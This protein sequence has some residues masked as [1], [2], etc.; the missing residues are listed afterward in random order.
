MEDNNTVWT[1][2]KLLSSHRIVIPE[3]QRDY[4][5]GR[6]DKHA[7]EIRKDIVTAFISALK[8]GAVAL[9]LDFIYGYSSHGIFIPLDGQQRLTTL[10]LLHLYIARSI[11]A[12]A[13]FLKNF[14]YETRQSATD[15]CTALAIEPI[16]FN[17]ERIGEDIEDQRWFLHSWK[18]DPT[19]C[20]MLRMLGEIHRQLAGFDLESLWV[21]LTRQDTSAIYF[22]FLELEQYNMQEDLYIKMNSRGKPLTRFENFKAWFQEHF[23]NNIGWHDKID[24]TWTNLFWPYRSA[25]TQNHVIDEEF[26][27]FIN[28]MLLYELSIRK[29][30]VGFR[31][32]YELVNSGADVPLSF[33]TEYS[34]FSENAVNYIEKTLDFL[35]ENSRFISEELMGLILWLDRE[36]KGEVPLFDNFIS[37][38][39]LLKSRVLFFALV[40]YAVNSKKGIPLIK[41]SL[42]QWMRIVRNLIENTTTLNQESVIDAIQ[43]LH[44]IGSECLDIEQR[45]GTKKGSI[46]FFN[47]DQLREEQEKLELFNRF[48]LREVIQEAENHSLFRG[49]VGFLLTE[50]F[51]PELFP[52]DCQAAASL[53]GDH[54]A[55]E[56]YKEGYLLIR[57]MLAKSDIDHTIRLYDN[58]EN[59]H[60]LLKN[61]KVRVAMH[62]I[63]IASRMF[64]DSQ[65][66]GYLNDIVNLYE[67]KDI[68]WRYY[69]IK[70]AV[71]LCD[72][73]RARYLREYHGEFY[74]FNNEGGNW[75]NNDNQFLLSNKRSEAITKLLKRDPS[76]IS[77]YDNKAHSI[78]IDSQSGRSHFRGHRVTLKKYCGAY[79]ARLNFLL[80]QVEVGFTRDE[81]PNIVGV[82]TETSNDYWICCERIMTGYSDTN[83]IVDDIDGKV[84]R[85]LQ[86]LESSL[87]NIILN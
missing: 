40:H 20:S 77:T 18:K 9:D 4:A 34:C 48:D 13:E 52:G 69:L 24:N 81:N 3:I 25:H 56:T 75:I 83:E 54:G 78:K 41:Q 62:K 10:Y 47:R 80:D 70:D 74:L 84:S 28:G 38:V 82:E 36:P 29:D 21:T 5:Q 1:L 30:A 32:L 17:V 71:L 50:I 53:F 79:T 61:E 76:Y 51:D 67:D 12:E 45:L 68:L 31:A 35:S 15:F 43:A 44:T 16:D 85:L 14:S 42:F 64:N 11:G 22:Q 27:Q 49:S 58:R 2:W 87:N 7:M 86:S 33:Y 6:A 39:V 73:S 46:D 23:P 65:I 72:S 19:V 8:P 55:R 63:I 59:W 66:L 26:M 60:D 57:A 37:K